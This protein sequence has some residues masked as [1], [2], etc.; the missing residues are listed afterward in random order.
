MKKG[1]LYHINMENTDK[2][3]NN[4]IKHK[5]VYTEAQIRAV[6]VFRERYRDFVEYQV[7]QRLKE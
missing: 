5:R 3:Y 7:K 4:E 2:I 6:K 1:F